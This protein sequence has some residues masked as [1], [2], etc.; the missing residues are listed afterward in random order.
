LEK[1]FRFYA[2]FEIFPEFK[3]RSACANKNVKQISQ[4]SSDFMPLKGGKE[5]SDVLV[6]L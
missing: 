2:I 3:D 5:G 6:E 1:Y 4:I